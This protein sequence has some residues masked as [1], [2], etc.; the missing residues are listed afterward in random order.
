M[1]IRRKMIETRWI[2]KA[3]N[4]YYK[5]YKKNR[6]L[7]KKIETRK[8]KLIGHIIRYNEFSTNI[9]IWKVNG[10]KLGVRSKKQYFDILRNSGTV[11]LFFIKK[12]GVKQK[13][14]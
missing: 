8:I 9:I 7:M 1:W 6:Q 4:K 11:R 5:K 12:C 14:E 10:K 2:H 13:E 3:I